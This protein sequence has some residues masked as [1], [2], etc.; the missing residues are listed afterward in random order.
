MNKGKVYLVGA[1]PGDEKLI[2]LRGMEVL[3]KADVIIYDRLANPELLKYRKESCRL[4]YVGKA[5][6]HHSMKQEDISERIASEAE[7]GNL[8]VRL[9]GGD[10]YVFGR[11]GEEGELLFERGIPFEVVPGVTAGIGGLAYAGIPITHRDYGSSLHLITGHKK[12][13][14][15]RLDYSALAALDGTMVFYMGVEN[16]PN[17]VR[18]L[19]SNG[20]EEDTK[21]ALISWA[22]YPHQ[23]VLLTDLKELSEGKLYDQI[24]PPVLTVIGN[25]VQLRDK[26]NFFETKPLFGKRIVVTRARTQAS[27]LSDKLKDLGAK[28]IECPAIG[29][30]A[31]NQD[32]IQ[33]EIERIK[34][35]THL[36]FTSQ[37]GVR[38]F[39]EELLKNKDVRSLSNLKIC[40]IGESTSK[41]LMNYSIRADIMPQRYIA[42][43]LAK[44]ICLDIEQSTGDARILVARAEQAREVLLDELRQHSQIK[45]LQEIKIYQTDAQ[46]IPEEIKA[47]LMSGVDVITFTSSSTVKNFYGMIDDETSAI[48]SE[49]KI[50][51]IGPIT[52]ETANGLNKKVTKQAQ[53]YTIDGLIEAVCEVLGIREEKLNV[54]ERTI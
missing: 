23:K 25:V 46:P 26:L 36:V 22:S 7:R 39:M 16:L 8:V 13:G 37:N 31:I 3:K 52:S 21:V 27:M 45:M 18:G 53:V 15:D 34:D 30:K 40:S 12:S 29:I 44:E 47:E 9:K 28:V 32:S 1:G 10:P 33:R 42:E 17:I 51:S 54:H 50:V 11:G 2:T 48:L 24:H 41:E 35:Y 4:V 5:S 20:K 14:K 6:S 19:L 49:T 38:I 43:E